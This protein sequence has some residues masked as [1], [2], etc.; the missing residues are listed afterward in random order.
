MQ[1]AD[2][3]R[4]STVGSADELDDGIVLSQGSGSGGELEL[5]LDWWLHPLPPEGPLRVVV[6]RGRG[7]RDTLAWAPPAPRGEQH[8]PGPDLPP[9]S[10]FAG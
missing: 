2:G 3:R 10:W 5:E 1:F 8:R 9:D 6:P 7:R 4:A